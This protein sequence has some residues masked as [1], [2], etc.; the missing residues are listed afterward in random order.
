MLQALQEQVLDWASLEQLR[1][2]LII[3]LRLLLLHRS[4]D[5]SRVLRTL[6]KVG[7]KYFI[8]VQRKGW[9]THRWEEILSFPDTPSI[10]PWHLVRAYVAKTANFVPEGSPLLITLH[11]PFKS[12]TA[13]TIGA[14]TG[15]IMRSFGIPRAWGP[16]STRGAGVL[17]Y[18]KLGLASEEVCQLGQWKNVGAFAAHYL[19]LEAAAAAKKKLQGLVHR[20]SPLEEAEPELS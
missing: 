18:K 20:T 11:S 12:L 19:R 4:V 14:I 9:K 1:S 17:M 6:S 8:L 13:D 5:L 7:G 15:R 16:H 2:R 10:S 3:V